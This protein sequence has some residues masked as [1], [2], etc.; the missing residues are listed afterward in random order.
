[1]ENVNVNEVAANNNEQNQNG[2]EL[3]KQTKK[4]DTNI[5]KLIA[6]MGG[7]TLDKKVSNSEVDELVTELLAEKRQQNKKVLKEGLNNLLDQKSNLDIE[8]TKKRA[9]FDKLV[10]QKYKEFNESAE[11]LFKLV[12]D[13][14]AIEQSYKNNLSGLNNKI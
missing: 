13:M 9:E 11:K 5:Q 14:N 12:E 2:G 3:V 7:K 4:F 10:A 1:M 8:I 6:V